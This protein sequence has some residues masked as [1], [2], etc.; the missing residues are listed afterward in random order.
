MKLSFFTRT[1][2]QS[3]KWV[4]GRIESLDSELKESKEWDEAWSG[5]QLG[6]GE[7]R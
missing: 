7:R 3:S 2:P 4:V 1:P 5:D 6:N